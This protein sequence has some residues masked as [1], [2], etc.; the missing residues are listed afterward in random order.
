MSRITIDVTEEQHHKI[1]VLASL[2]KKTVKALLLE[3]LS[4]NLKK[5]YNTETLQALEDIKN[6]NGLN[7]YNTVDELFKE[8][9]L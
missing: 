2:Q 7:S 5:S 1:K 8:L 3:G 4:E 9:D 6:K